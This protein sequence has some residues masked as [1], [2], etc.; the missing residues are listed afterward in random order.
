MDKKIS[1][2]QGEYTEFLAFQKARMEQPVLVQPEIAPEI[3]V[4]RAIEKLQ[5][6]PYKGINT[7]FSGF[8]MAFKKY[9]GEGSDPSKVTTEMIEKGLIDGRP[10]KKGTGKV[11]SFLI[12]KKGEMPKGFGW[13]KKADDTLKSI[14]S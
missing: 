6:P 5:K 2:S 4:V 14:L 7:V 10:V 1:I 11:G 8:N 9:Y 12:Y 3:F 13:D